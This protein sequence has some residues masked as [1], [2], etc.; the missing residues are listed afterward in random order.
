[1]DHFR[2]WQTCL[3]LLSTVNMDRSTVSY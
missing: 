3:Q 2:V 1:V